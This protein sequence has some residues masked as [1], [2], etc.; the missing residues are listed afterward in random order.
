MLVKLFGFLC[1]RDRKSVIQVNSGWRAAAETSCLW[2]WV[3]LPKVADQDSCQRVIGMLK[4]NRL[5]NV[6]FLSLRV[7]ANAVSDNLIKEMN[8]HAGIKWFFLQDGGLPAGLDLQ[9]MMKAIMKMEV[10]D[11][12]PLSA[13]L[14]KLPISVILC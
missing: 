11:I 13:H 3:R 7:N 5:K 8:R 10:F 2:D 4:S 14:S 9:L 6:K 12:G 1:P